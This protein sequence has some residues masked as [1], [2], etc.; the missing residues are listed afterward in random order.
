MGEPRWTSSSTLEVA[1]EKMIE[2]GSKLDSAS[3]EIRVASKKVHEVGC[4][5][6]VASSMFQVATKKA[7]AMKK[8]PEP[9][10]HP[11]RTTGAC[12]EFNGLRAVEGV[13]AV[14]PSHPRGA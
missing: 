1:R 4:K 14:M 2:V 12:F 9:R 11:E 7:T 3:S 13:R 5:V 10:Q 8:G 6:D